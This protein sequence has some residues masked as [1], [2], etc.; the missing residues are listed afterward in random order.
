MKAFGVIC[1]L[2]LVVCAFG[3]RV[4]TQPMQI[5]VAGTRYELAVHLKGQAVA[6]NVAP[7]GTLVGAQSLTAE[8]IDAVLIECDSPAKSTGAAWVDAGNQYG[9]DAA[10]AV[11][12]FYHESTCGSNPAW[13]GIKPDGTT[14]HNVGNIICA[15][16]A[17]CYGRFRDYPDWQTGINDWFRLIAIEYVQQRGL[18]T[19]AG[20]IPV[21][22]PSADNNDVGGYIGAVNELVTEWRAR[23]I[24]TASDKRS[25]LVAYA[26]SLEGIP[27]VRGGR[28]ASGG[29][30]SGTMQHIFLTVAGI[31]ISA[32]TFSQFPALKPIELAQVQP[33]DLAYFDGFSDGDEHVG[34]IADVNGDGTWDLINNGGLQHN[35]HIDYSFLDE[36][37]F[38][39]HLKGFRT[40]L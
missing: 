21:Y 34:M 7:I 10:Y 15:G 25:L 6:V 23:P 36:P 38:N 27:Y 17:T 16:Y 22:A 31:D 30:C 28:S 13:A 8:Q 5:A 26:I 14:T 35:M 4:Y 18:T 24:V 33:G 39:Q 37:Y 1:G 40:A 11:A 32:T 3:Y 9:I 12:F 2:M 20:I 19:V 29:D